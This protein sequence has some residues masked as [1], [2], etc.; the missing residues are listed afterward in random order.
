MIIN[1][2]LTDGDGNLLVL[3]SQPSF[4]SSNINNIQG[5]LDPGE[6]ETYIATYLISNSAAA[7][8][9]LSNTV[10]VR[11]SSGGQVNNVS[12]ISDDGDDTD[13][14]TSNDP[15]IVEISVEV[16]DASIE[17]TKTAQITDNG[18]NEVEA[19]D[20][21]TYDIS[22]EN[23]GD[24]ILKNLT[25]E[26]VLTD[27]N[28]SNL[29]LSN[30]PFFA[31]SNMNSNSGTI[32]PGEIANYIAFYIIEQQAADTGKILNSVI[33]TASTSSATVVSDTSDDG[34]DNDGNI[35]DDPTE[36]FIA[37]RPGIEVV[38]TAQITDNGDGKIDFGDIITY[39]ITVSNTG[40]ITLSSIRI[41]DTLTD[42]NGNSLTLSNGPYFSGSTKGSNEGILQVEEQA[43]Y[44]AFYIIQ[45]SA[46]ITSEIINSA[47]AFASSHGFQAEVSDISDD[48]DDTDGNLIDDPTVVYISSA[49]KIE[50]TKTA[51]ISDENSDGKTGPGDII[52]YTITVE[53]TGNISLS[54][55]KLIDTM[56]DGNGRSL[57]LTTG[58][59][60]SDSSMDSPSGI[61]EVDE[62][63][64][65]LATYR[66]MDDDV[67]GV[68]IENSI[69]ALASSPDKID[70]VTD[71]SDD[72]DDNDGNT[73]DDPTVIDINYVPPYFE[74]FNLVTPNNDGFNEYFKIAGI[75][76]FP[77]NQVLIYN[78]W[79]VLIYEM[80]N[81][82]N[83][84]NSENVFIGF[85]DGR[86]TI[87]QGEKLPVG[88]YF[89]VINFSGI[90]PG[91]RSYSGYLYL[92]E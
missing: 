17:V 47:H 71:V 64:T 34:D 28:G 57:R 41:E 36:V 76:N 68:L 74:V 26:D 77:E 65:Y 49:P 84:S 33:A 60:H 46:A 22:V 78:R 50:V 19:G 6:I 59:T 63:A 7:T 24:V 31:G 79:G 18:D 62:I 80:E 66:I 83:S 2:N 75:E 1:E 23:T 39:T 32:L 48:G 10:E 67:D 5:T 13:G 82:G 25:I 11:G 53:N 89:Y 8:G 88:T 51:L 52:S 55:I 54:G 44:I 56:S 14:N 27:G 45:Q 92:N 30:G 16:G 73:V 40:N 72:G 69:L 43:T 3:T 9:L 20:I 35:K 42:G 4:L 81:Y 61:L 87:N 21:I 58:P 90:N 86:I 91:R 38:K 15:T 29:T 85:S 12:D 37:P 70:D